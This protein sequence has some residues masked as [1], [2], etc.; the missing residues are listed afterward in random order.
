MTS[1]NQFRDTPIKMNMSNILFLFSRE[2]VAFFKKLVSKLEGKCERHRAALRRLWSGGYVVCKSPRLAGR[3]PTRSVVYPRRTPY[4]T[5][6]LCATLG[7][8]D[9]L[10]LR[11][12]YTKETARD[13]R[14]HVV[15]ALSTAQC[16]EKRFL[17][18]FSRSKWGAILDFSSTRTIPRRGI[19]REQAIQEI[20]RRM[21]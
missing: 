14:K 11:P 12:I 9:F 10:G 18:F 16:S 7:V 21:S 5:R 4:K 13:F 1:S 2:R 6:R 15:L 20:L 19:F 3:V 17:R 8:E